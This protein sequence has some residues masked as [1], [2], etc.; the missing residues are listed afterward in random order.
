VISVIADLDLSLGGQLE[1]QILGVIAGI[2]NMRACSTTSVVAD[3]DVSI[4]TQGSPADQ[5]ASRTA[6]SRAAA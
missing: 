4:V 1:E 5:V 6:R 3:A 2:D